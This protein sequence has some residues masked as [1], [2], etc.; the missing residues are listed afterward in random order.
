[1]SP[2]SVSFFF[3]ANVEAAFLSIQNLV[4]NGAFKE[5]CKD[6]RTFGML[7]QMAFYYMI[8]LWNGLQYD[9]WLCIKLV[10]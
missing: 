3:L 6:E 4:E 7:R 2:D 10:F 9:R 5:L 8:L 1:M